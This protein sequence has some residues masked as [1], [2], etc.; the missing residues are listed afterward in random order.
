MD[1][2]FP[3]RTMNNGIYRIVSIINLLTGNSLATRNTQ[4]AYI[5]ILV[6]DEYVNSTFIHLMRMNAA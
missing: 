1:R 6:Q 5:C 4:K 3:E 2:L